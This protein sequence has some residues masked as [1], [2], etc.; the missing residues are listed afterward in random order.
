V[1]VAATTER[2]CKDS[3]ES[4][5]H[6]QVRQK[7][8]TRGFECRQPSLVGMLKPREL[9]GFCSGLGRRDKGIWNAGLVPLET[10]KGGDPWRVGKAIVTNGVYKS[11]ISLYFGSN[12]VTESLASVFDGQS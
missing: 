4:G 7:E 5:C 6:S 1:R 9:V 11:H 2:R 10:M 12:I 3:Q 8:C